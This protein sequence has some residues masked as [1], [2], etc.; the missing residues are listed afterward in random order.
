[1]LKFKIVRSLQHDSVQPHHPQG[2]FA[3]PG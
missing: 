1:M 2:A 3:K